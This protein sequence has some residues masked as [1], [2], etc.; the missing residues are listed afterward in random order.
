MRKVLLIPVA[1]ALISLAA[2][3]GKLSAPS[4]VSG[5]VINGEIV[6]P[7]GHI[8]V[9]LNGDPTSLDV[10]RFT[11]LIDRTVLR[12]ILEPLVVI[13]DGVVVPAGAASY[14]VTP[15]GL[16]YTFHLRENY[17]SDGKRVTAD[18]YALSFRRQVSPDNTFRFIDNIASISN[19]TEINEGK[20]DIGELG[21]KAVDDNTLVITL[22]SPNVEFLT[23]E[24]FFPSRADYVEKYGDRLGTEAETLIANGPFI[25]KEW[26]HDSRLSF[27]KNEKY[28]DAASVRL[29]SFDY[30]IIG[31]ATARESAFAN[32]TIDYYRATSNIDYINKIRAEPGIQS[33]PYKSGRTTMAVFN[34]RNRYFSSQKIRQAFSVAID[35][36]SISSI[37]NGGLSSPAYGLIP[38]ISSVGSLNFRT[39]VPEPLLALKAQYPDP[40]ALLIEGL[41]EAGLDPNPANVTVTYCVSSTNDNAQ[42]LAEFYQQMWQKAL[43][44]R[45]EVTLK[46]NASH[47]ADM[48]AGNYDFGLIG[49]GAN[50]EPQ[51]HLSRWNNGDDSGW[52]NDEYV[53]LVSGA[54]TVSDENDRLRLYAEAEGILITEAPFG[55]I[56]YI[57]GVLLTQDYVRGIPSNAFDTTENKTV[58]VVKTKSP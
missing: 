15:D 40:K 43:G 10:S 30:L 38:D 23:T 53:R 5:E 8:N 56:A 57:G 14:D 50:L 27:V 19:V 13:Q 58:Y 9:L 26:I 47:F 3:G 54:V 35:R 16:T 18:D 44:V 4:P 52:H 37:L 1:L 17:W 48:A 29:G 51:F 45:V 28:W 22:I 24:E 42:V 25:L 41:K 7:Q 49:W 12:A 20:T 21:V 36:E 39:K 31:N 2:C 46:D 32:R 34:T 33:V 6:N 11:V 55:P